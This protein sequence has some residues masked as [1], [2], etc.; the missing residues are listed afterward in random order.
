MHCMEILGFEAR[1]RYQ[2]SPPYTLPY[3]AFLHQIGE[4]GVEIVPCGLAARI[5]PWRRLVLF[6]TQK[7]ETEIVYHMRCLVLA[8]SSRSVQELTVTPELRNLDFRLRRHEW[9]EGW[10]GQLRFHEESLRVI[11]CWQLLA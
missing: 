6:V 4:G 3:H 1:T 11:T 7:C 10:I 2:V 5:D 9:L 8:K